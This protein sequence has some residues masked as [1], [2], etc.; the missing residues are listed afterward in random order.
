V[1]DWLER[2]LL[3]TVVVVLVLLV[4]LW[5]TSRSGTR[6]LQTWGIPYPQPE[7]VAE[8]V[9]YLRQR[10]VLYLVLVLVFPPLAAFLLRDDAD[11]PG[12]GIFVPLVVAMLVAELVAT[13]RPVSGVRVAT[14]A[15]RGW[16]DLVPRW[17]VVATAVLVAV[18][19]CAVVLGPGSA[20][21][22]W[23]AVGYVVVC[24]IVVALLVHLAV[25]RPVV[26]DEAVDAALRMR[27]ARVAVGVG[28]GWLGAAVLL[29][30]R[31]PDV[32]WEIAGP[33]VQLAAVLAW[34]W[35]ANPTRP[36]LARR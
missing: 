22:R 4:V 10:R 14:L 5:P 20:R 35:L 9:R 16:R 15:P 8:A 2:T 27:T 28:F 13:L 29:A 12:L 30:V 18:A 31:R 26:A 25:R 23:V 19:L 3:P 24:L 21:E 32:E 36:T 33:L 17:A 11:L 7:Q 6:L 1:A 34:I